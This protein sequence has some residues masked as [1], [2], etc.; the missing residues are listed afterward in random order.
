MYDTQEIDIMG[1]TAWL[2]LVFGI[3]LGLNVIAFYLLNRKKDV[4][5]YWED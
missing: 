4:R 2:I 1:W 5:K 3:W